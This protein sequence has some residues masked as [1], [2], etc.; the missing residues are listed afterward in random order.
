M[1]WRTDFPHLYFKLLSNGMSLTKNDGHEYYPGIHNLIYSIMIWKLFLYKSNLRNTPQS[2]LVL[3]LKMK[4]N[5]SDQ[6]S[7]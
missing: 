7:F 6:K 4:P 2:F 5:R 3:L 1:L